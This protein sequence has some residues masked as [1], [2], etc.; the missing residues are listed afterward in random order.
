VVATDAFGDGEG[1]AVWVELERVVMPV[2]KERSAHKAGTDVVKVDVTDAPYVAELGEAF[3]IM[4][5]IAFGGGI[6]WGGTQATCAGNAADDSEM[7]FLF[8]MF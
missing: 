4:I 3:H 7:A 1:D 6:G 8:G 5:Y 2:I